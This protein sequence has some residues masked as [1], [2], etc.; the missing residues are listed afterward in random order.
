MLRTPVFVRD[1]E[2]PFGEDLIVDISGTQDA[3]L[4]V[5]AKVCSLIEVLRL[6][7]NCE[8][9]YQLRSQFTPTAGWVNVYVMWSRD[10]VLVSVLLVQYF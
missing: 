4:P 1:T 10:E 2:Y 3:M 8:L 5:L 6:G 9:L 7:G